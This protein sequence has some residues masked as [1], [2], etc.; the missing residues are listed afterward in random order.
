[1]N[2]V[3]PKFFR[4]SLFCCFL[5]LLEMYRRFGEEVVGLRAK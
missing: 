1:M 4:N 3:D 5:T 2:G